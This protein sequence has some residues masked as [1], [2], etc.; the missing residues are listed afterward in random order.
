MDERDFYC[1]YLR[2]SEP[3]VKGTGLINIAGKED[4]FEL[5]SSLKM[6]NGARGVG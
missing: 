3:T 6:L 1:P 4:P 2:S 5:D